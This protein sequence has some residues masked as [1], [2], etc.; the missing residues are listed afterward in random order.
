MQKEFY[1]TNGYK[2]IYYPSNKKANKDGLIFEHIVKAEEMLGRELKEE[3]IVHHKDRNRSNNSPDN[4]MVFA[5]NS[6]H[7]R[8]HKTGIAIKQDDVYI[9]PKNPKTCIDCGK[10]I[11]YGATRCVDC[12]K[13]INKRK[14]PSKE[15]L[16]KLIHEKSFEAIGRQY[17]VTGNA[18]KK[19]C[20]FYNLPYRKK[21]L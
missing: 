5:S 10:E 19:W 3:E 20:K 1:Y 11:S 13:E 9:S 2:K 15:E 6:D 21:D 17:N 14:K 4:L 7:S 18:I 12:Y 16:N 8:F